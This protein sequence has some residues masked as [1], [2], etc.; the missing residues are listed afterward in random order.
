MEDGQRSECRMGRGWGGGWSEEGSEDCQRSEW[1]I[2]KGV[3]GGW[4]EE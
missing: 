2:V 1:R 3:N 4:T